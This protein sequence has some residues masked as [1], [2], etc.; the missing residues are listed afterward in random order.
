MLFCIEK[1]YIVRIVTRITPTLIIFQYSHINKDFILLITQQ[2]ASYY[3][4]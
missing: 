2:S 1:K 3:I 4:Y